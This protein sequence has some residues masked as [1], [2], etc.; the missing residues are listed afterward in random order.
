MD[1]TTEQTSHGDGPAPD[2]MPDAPPVVGAHEP[3]PPETAPRALPAQDGLWV[4]TAALW[5]RK[6]LLIGLTVLAAIGGVVLSLNLPVWYRAETR[7]L[8]PN[9][10]GGGGMSS[11]IESVAP[12]A[13]ALLGGGGGG[14]YTRYLA[15]L[16]SRSVMEETVR[17]FDLVEAYETEGEANPVA[18]AAGMLSENVTFEVS[19]EYNFLSIHVLDQS[20]ERAAQIANNFVEIL[21]RDNTRLSSSSAREQRVFVETRLRESE[22]ELDSVR[23]VMQ[24]LQ[25]RYG[26]T[27]PMAQAEALMA[28]VGAATGAVAEA[29]VRYEALRSQFGDDGNPDVAAA[30]AALSTARAQLNSLTSGGSALLPVPMRQ[31]PQVARQYSQLQQEML[32]QAKILEFVRPMYEQS[33]FDE[34]LTKSAVQVVDTAVPPTRKAAPKRALVVVGVTASVFVLAALFIMLSALLRANAAYVVS[35]LRRASAA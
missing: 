35:R 30:G 11:L 33:L 22:Q 27:E 17:Q 24:R 31:L 29:E 16:T 28:S 20:P 18:V 14:D 8:L 7:V 15:I 23:V 6:W 5:R 3:A 13:G 19:L 1:L 9:S 34:R 26:V 32:I 12:G 2:F 21:N 4:A 25:E 10:G